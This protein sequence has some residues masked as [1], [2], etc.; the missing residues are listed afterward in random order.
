MTSQ[1]FRSLRGSRLSALDVQPARSDVVSNAVVLV[2]STKQDVNGSSWNPRYRFSAME[3]LRKKNVKSI[4]AQRLALFNALE[5]GRPRSDTGSPQAYTGDQFIFNRGISQEIV[6]DFQKVNTLKSPTRKELFEGLEN[7]KPIYENMEK[8]EKGQNSSG[9]EPRSTE[10]VITASFSVRQLRRIFE[11]SSVPLTARNS[12]GEEAPNLVSNGSQRTT[13]TPNA[14][15][16]T[17]SDVPQQDK[18]G[19][20]EKTELSTESPRQSPLIKK[21]PVPQPKDF[22][23]SRQAKT[24]PAASDSKPEPFTTKTLSSD[25]KVQEANDKNEIKD[26]KEARG[27]PLPPKNQPSFLSH[28]AKEDS[29][30]CSPPS[31]LPPSK[32]LPKLPNREE[33][34]KPSKFTCE[35]ENKGG[36]SSPRK[37]IGAIGSVYIEPTCKAEKDAKNSVESSEKLETVPMK[38]R[39]LGRGD[40]KPYEIVS[41]VTPEKGNNNMN[42]A[43]DYGRQKSSKMESMYVQTFGDLDGKS[44]KE[45]YPKDEN[46]YEEIV[47]YSEPEGG[48]IDEV[49]T[50]EID[51]SN[52]DFK[53]QEVT[54]TGEQ[55]EKKKF[56]SQLEE[57][58]TQEHISNDEYEEI[59]AKAVFAV[60]FDED[61]LT[62][63]TQSYSSS[64]ADFRSRSLDSSALS[65]HEDIS[66]TWESD[67]FDEYTDDEIL[68]ELKHRKKRQAIGVALHS[69][70]NPM[71]LEAIIIKGFEFDKP[72]HGIEVTVLIVF[73]VL[74]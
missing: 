31:R 70:C 71:S 2:S 24:L 40:I 54:S 35:K 52:L 23:N 47:E 9:G 74:I 39:T 4:V 19:L 44:T 33:T 63:D 27:P 15:Y 14:E 36:V 5:S 66:E 73:N 38:K 59:P 69:G 60:S 53:S 16:L 34:V 48:Q 57:R 68:D 3:E 28:K 62:D 42:E 41:I 49:D 26:E 11:S 10:D 37:D 67:E 72:P 8:I 30:S 55:K 58:N 65:M 64:I 51:L 13:E 6:S 29:Q 43:K 7:N 1:E 22:V 25:W 17:N 61:E 46:G 18:K 21:K 50:D 12:L 56:T 32:P 45:N 20:D